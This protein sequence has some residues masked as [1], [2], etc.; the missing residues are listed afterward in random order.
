MGIR[1]RSAAGRR[2]LA[3]LAFVLLASGSLWGQS[4]SSSLRGAIQDETAA[5]IPGAVATLTNNGTGAQLSTQSDATG[6]Y[7]F[8]QVPP[9]MYDLSVESDGFSTAAVAGIELLVDTPV[10]LDVTLAVGQVSEVVSVEADAVAVNTTDATV[11]NAFNQTKVRQLPLLTRNVVELL[12]YQ[13]GVNQTGEVLGAR[14]DQNNVTL[15]GVDVNDNQ[16][17]DPFG[18]VLPVPLDS[19]QEFRT[20]TAGGN[21][22]TGR[23]SGGQ[24]SL[25]TKSGTNQFHGS[26]YEFHRNTKTA[27]NTFFNNKAGV[28]REALI[29]N[30][31]GASV[32][33]PIV[34]NKLFFFANWEQRRDARSA[35]QFRTVPSEDLKRGIL[36]VQASDGNI[37]KLTPEEFRLADPAGI[38]T[39]QAMLDILN[40]F[41]AGNDPSA[42]SDG[43]QNFSGLRFNAPLQINNNAYVGKVDYNIDQAGSH[44]VFWRGTLADNEGDLEQS[45]ARYPGLEANKLLNNSRG[46][47]AR[48]TGVFS[49][50]IIN[51]FSFGFT[52]LSTLETGATGDEFFLFDIDETQD[53]DQRAQRRFSPVWNFANDL[54]WVKGNHNYKFGTNIRIIRNNRLNFANAWPEYGLSQGLLG[55][56]GADIQRGINDVLAGVAGPGVTVDDSQ[57]AT[58]SGA[59]LNL[60]GAVTGITAIYQY[61]QQGNVLPLGSPARRE[62]AT[63]EYEF[64]MSDTWNVTPSLTINYGLRYSYGT[65][66]YERQGLQG[67]PTT[68]TE[69]YLANRVGAQ[70]L[71]IPNNQLPT[72]LLTWEANGPLNGRDS[73]YTPDRNNWAPRLGVAWSPRNPS[74]ALRS[75]FG[76]NGVLRFGTGIYYDRYGSR[77]VTQSDE[78]GT[79]GVQNRTS[80]PQT[81]NFTTAARF[82][83]GQPNLPPA[84]PGGF[85]VTP[86]L[87]RAIGGSGIATATNLRAPYSIPLTATFERE[88]PSGFAMSVGYVGR[89]GRKLLTQLD[90]ASPLIN[91][92]DPASGQTLAEALRANRTLMEGGLTNDQVLADPTLVPVQPFFEN[93]FAP[94]AGMAVNGSASANFFIAN[95]EW[96]RESELDTIDQID[97]QLN[98]FNG[99]SFLP[100]GGNFPNCI[101]VT[102]CHSF[103]GS[104]FSALRTWENAG[105]SNFHGMTLGLRKVSGPLTVDFNYTW[106]RSID[107]GSAA[108]GNLAAPGIS[109]DE[110][111]STTAG[112]IVNIFDRS[113]NRGVSDFDI[114][115]QFNTNF[116]WEIPFAKGTRGVLKQMFDGWQA[117]GLVRYSTGLPWDVANG[118]RWS[119][120]FYGS[121]RARVLGSVPNEQGDNVNGNPSFIPDGT[122]AADN[123]AFNVT[124]VNGPRNYLRLNNI[125]N[126]DLAFGKRF[127][128]PLEGHSLQFRA[129]LFNAFNNT[130]FRTRS[131]QSRFDRPNVLGEYRT[132]GAPRVIQFALRYEF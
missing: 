1:I 98:P 19:V 94:L 46:M 127:F 22:D 109:E 86:P 44:R 132:S 73:W 117:S 55:G 126:T 36:S 64:Y 23:S 47:S 2:L 121:G 5:R 33:G 128:I 8:L 129:E 88:L 3:L 35:S 89:L 53:F 41:P 54:N 102:G 80:D 92:R 37:Y 9:G 71:G 26:L 93:M 124:G 52:R 45:L 13:T 101:V 21:A 48:Y 25:V 100:N 4:G 51:T 57:L 85:P 60:T 59:A 24:V 79:F 115:Q 42:G 91:F 68:P 112:N 106:S 6:V 58:I 17:P 130:N 103:F 90:P 72:A 97:R 107:I 40:Q 30:Q 81:Y 74:G 69:V 18:S 27:A 65:P 114:N 49:P 7:Q 95:N 43:G 28:E 15:D 104:Q 10:T 56:L 125:V 38:G 12:S 116:V 11:G 14:K 39:N 32:G 75:I 67:A 61:D 50:S 99:T 82:Q 122:V 29:R 105:F 131:I 70:D 111:F 96:G 113:Q 78:F 123:M 87:N 83:G 66:P 119:I 110:T 108:E 63:E 84:P 76:D 118:S 16:S 62:F 20:T 31:F 34:K 120:N 77:L